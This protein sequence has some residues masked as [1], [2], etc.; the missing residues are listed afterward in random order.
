MHEKAVLGTMFQTVFTP[1]LQIPLTYKDKKQPFCRV[2]TNFFVIADKATYLIATEKWKVH[3]FRKHSSP[4]RTKNGQNSPLT[5]HCLRFIYKSRFCK[6][7][8]RLSAH[9]RRGSDD[10]SPNPF[11]KYCVH[12]G[13]VHFILTNLFCRRLPYRFS[14]SPNGRRKDSAISC[15]PSRKP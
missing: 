6:Q 5:T 8:M 15:T 4:N 9:E 13:L 2:I 11:K 7:K 3:P 12:L 10:A 14:S 1:C